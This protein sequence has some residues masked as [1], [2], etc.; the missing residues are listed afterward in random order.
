VST[1]TLTPFEERLLANLERHRQELP[2][3]PAARSVRRRPRLLRP[4]LVALALAAGG[5][6]AFVLVGRLGGDTREATSATTIREITRQTQSAL[7]GA[8]ELIAHATQHD[9]NGAVT[10]T[11]DDGVAHRI[12]TELRLDGALSRVTVFRGLPG[13]VRVD[14]VNYNARTWETVTTKL[15]PGSPTL[16]SRTHLP[17]Q[18][19]DRLRR[20]SLALVGE[21][22]VQGHDTLHL[23]TLPGFGAGT[24]GVQNTRLDFWVDAGTYLPVRQT[25]HSSVNGRSIG[26]TIDYEWLPRTPENVAKTA[27][28]R[29][30]GFTHTTG[31]AP[32]R[33]QI[34]STT[35]AFV[36][37]GARP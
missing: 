21:E 14:A 29:L 19:R 2:E 27:L 33:R 25:T 30:E 34:G 11:W 9:A 6:A 5:A 23:R 37:V 36:I 20:G 4:A 3:L 22:V 8:G 15:P 26:A 32:W 24:R 12:L 28:G 16:G 18:L 17:E 31:T 35:E 10:E 7:A 13:K 1:G